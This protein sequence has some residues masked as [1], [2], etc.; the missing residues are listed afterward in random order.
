MDFKEKVAASWCCE[1]PED[2]KAIAEALCEGSKVYLEIIFNLVPE[3][4]E[5]TLAIRRLQESN[6]WIRQAFCC[7][8]CPP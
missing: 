1:V 7:E 5:R 8:E 4:P 2:K 6:F 3:C